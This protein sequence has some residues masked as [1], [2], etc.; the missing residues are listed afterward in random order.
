MRLTV[1]LVFVFLNFAGWCLARTD[2][3]AFV[4]IPLRG[5]Q[6]SLQPPA[7]GFEQSFSFALVS[8]SLPSLAHGPGKNAR[9]SSRSYDHREVRDL[10]FV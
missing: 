3:G 4:L 10:A 6:Q 7:G 8:S 1:A 5:P 9:S 2:V